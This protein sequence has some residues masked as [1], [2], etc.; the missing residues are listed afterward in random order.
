MSDTHNIIPLPR[1]AQVDPYLADR[2]RLTDLLLRHCLV[3]T[4]LAPFWGMPF[5]SCPWNGLP[6]LLLVILG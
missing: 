2:A 4:D 5:L 3:T 1:S 6:G